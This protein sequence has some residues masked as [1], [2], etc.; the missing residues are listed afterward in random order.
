MDSELGFPGVNPDTQRAR[1]DMVGFC[2]EFGYDG[3]KVDKTIVKPGD[4]GVT[5]QLKPLKGGSRSKTGRRSCIRSDDTRV[6]FGLKAMN[7]F[8]DPYLLLDVLQISYCKISKSIFPSPELQK[9]HDRN[10]LVA[11]FDILTNSPIIRISYDNQKI[12]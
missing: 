11:D 8:R 10:Y 5:V 6:V 4:L 2:I 3:G 7:L 1:E 9:E 12:S